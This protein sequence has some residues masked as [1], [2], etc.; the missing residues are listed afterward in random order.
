M[1][2]SNKILIVV[3]VVFVAFAIV[4]IIDANHQMRQTQQ[5]MR[6]ILEQID[7]SDIRVIRMVR[8]NDDYVASNS[9]KHYNSRR[10]YFSH[11]KPDDSSLRIEG[12]TLVI[13]HEGRVIVHIPSA[14]HII[15]WDGTV[16]ELENQDSGS[17]D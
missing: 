11:C 2:T 12:D 15:E 4:Q 16:R 1:K 6:P 3:S 14:T 9:T 13:T 8:H 10:L 17:E 7:S 5:I